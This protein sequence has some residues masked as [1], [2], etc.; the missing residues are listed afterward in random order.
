MAKT[1]TPAPTQTVNWRLPTRIASDNAGDWD[2][3]REHLAAWAES[4]EKLAPEIDDTAPAC[5]R[6]PVSIV[7]ALE[8]EA[9][10]LSKKHGK[11]FTAG[12]VARLV[13]DTWEPS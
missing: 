4:G 3:L 8:K 1:D 9:V 5:M 11:R 10:R 13:W 7:K 6:M 12:S 2:P